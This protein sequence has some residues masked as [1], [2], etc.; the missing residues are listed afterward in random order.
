MAGPFRFTAKQVTEHTYQ[1]SPGIY[2]IRDRPSVLVAL[3][4]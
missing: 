4:I 1:K 2:R 3:F